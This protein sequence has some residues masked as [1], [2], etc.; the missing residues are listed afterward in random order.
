MNSV[1][2]HSKCSSAYCLRVNKDNDQ[3]CR[4]HFPFDLTNGT[5]IR[6]NKVNSKTGLFFR[7][8]IVAKRNDSRVNRHQQVQLQGWRANCDIQLVT[9]HHA[10][11]EY[12]AKYASKAERMSSVAR[13]AFC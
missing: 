10:C 8:E 13:D 7:P 1:Q 6:Y 11:V 9:D 3:Y 12:L 5:F 4:F 2:R